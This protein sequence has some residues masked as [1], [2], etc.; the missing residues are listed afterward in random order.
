[1]DGGVAQPL[2]TVSRHTGRPLGLVGAQARPTIGRVR[3]GKTAQE[4]GVF[5][6]HP[7]LPL[8]LHDLLPLVPRGRQAAGGIASGGIVGP[9][10][11]ACRIPST[12]ITRLTRTMLGIGK[13]RITR[14][15]P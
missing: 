11:L 14:A 13:A 5:G 10:G 9:A 6:R 2:H 4:R 15:A 12:G 3:I 1:M 8:G 7:G